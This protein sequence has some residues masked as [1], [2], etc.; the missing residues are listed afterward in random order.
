MSPKR[1]QRLAGGELE[2]LVLDVLW[3]SGEWL[4]PREVGEQLRPRH[5]LAYTSVL[6]ILVRLWNKELLDRRAD[7][8][9]FA[10]R[11]LLTR[12]ETA[13]Q[14]MRDLL[15]TS[16]DHTAALTH[17]LGGLNASDKTRLRNLLQRRSGR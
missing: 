6:T 12:E 16:G 5:P 4:T 9:A 15:D 3:D 2:A 10:Y 1:S 17:F 8:R 13:A 11:P 7:G 14:Q